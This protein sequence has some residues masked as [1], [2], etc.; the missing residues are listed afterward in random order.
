MVFF[1]AIETL[2]Q[3]RC[4]PLLGFGLGENIEIGRVF[5]DEN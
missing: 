3:D 4:D 1:A 2:D 5:R